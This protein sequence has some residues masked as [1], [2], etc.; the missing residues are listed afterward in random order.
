MTHIG[1]KKTFCCVYFKLLS[2]C[3]YTTERKRKKIHQV[4]FLYGFGQWRT[5]HAQWKKWPFTLLLDFCV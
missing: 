3:K 2:F 5:T 1:K 4:I